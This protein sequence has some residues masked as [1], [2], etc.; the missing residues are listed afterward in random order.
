[1]DSIMGFILRIGALAIFILC[2]DGI[3]PDGHM[4][5]A[6]ICGWGALIYAELEDIKE[7]LKNDRNTKHDCNWDRRTD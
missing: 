1:M 2:L 5:G 4:T 7:I 3:I 6:T